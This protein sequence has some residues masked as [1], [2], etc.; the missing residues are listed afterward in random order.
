MRHLAFNHLLGA[1]LLFWRPALLFICGQR[2][3]DRGQRISQFVREKRQEFVFA[4][5]GIPKRLF[6][7]AQS[8]FT[9][10]QRLFRRLALGNVARDFGGAN[11]GPCRIAHRRYSERYCNATAGV[12]HTNCVEMIH[13]LAVSYPVQDASLFFMELWWNDERDRL[14]DC[15]TRL[16]PEDARGAGVP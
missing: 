3:A 4:A 15:L 2:I 5:I 1:F 11:D 6:A 13:T 8:L 14:T 10:A 7:G 16:I 12:G 9:F